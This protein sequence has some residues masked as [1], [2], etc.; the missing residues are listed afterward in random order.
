MKAYCK[1]C[2]GELDRTINRG[3]DHDIVFIKCHTCEY[4]VR[5]EF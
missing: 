4:E 3:Q 2:L 5:V 1:K